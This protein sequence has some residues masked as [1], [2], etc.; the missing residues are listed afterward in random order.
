MD[1]RSHSQEP[2]GTGP[3]RKPALSAFL[4]A[5]VT[6]LLIYTIWAWAGLRPSFQVAAVAAAWI[7]LGGLMFGGGAASWRAATRDPVFYLGLLFLL[8]LVLQ[9]ANAGRMQYFDAGY[10][11]W[12]Y[13][14]PR[15]RGWPSAFAAADARQMLAWFFP[16]WVLVLVLR[17]PWLNR[18]ELRSLLMWLA[19]SAGL[20]AAFG[21]VQY[22]SG[23]Q[24]I[25]WRQPLSS[26]FFASFAYG[27]HA[28]AFFVLA[29]AL[30]AGL[31]YREVFDARHSPADTPSAAR[32]RHPGRVVF[33][34]PVLVLCLL[35]AFLGF[36]RAGVILAGLLVAFVVGY[37]WL[38][39]WR[40]L[41]PAARVN[42]AALS[43]AV[44]AVLF[45]AVASVG[46]TG[47][48]RE[49]RRLALA[50]GAAPTLW[51]HVDRE[52]GR[53]P[54]FVWAALQ[55]WREHPWVGTGGWGFKYLVAERVPQE[56]W[57][58]LE[59]R[60]W[61]NVHCD[62]V[63]FLAEFGLV[64]SGLLLAAAGTLACGLCDRRRCRRDALWVMGVAGLGLVVLFS[65]VDLPFRSPA[66]LY[67][68]V[69]VLAVLP[70]LCRSSFKALP[71]DGPAPGGA[72][73]PPAPPG[74]GATV[75]ERTSR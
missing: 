57:P 34:V 60:G 23:T 40:V 59:R 1:A 68:W 7:L 10:R 11:K 32:L 12:M 75:E 58:A 50:P 8:L 45:F 6:G 54:H 5:G 20:L 70:R 24:A 43:L 51:E 41:Q 18:R 73:A 44:A 3:A 72:G 53:R 55:I 27:N 22:L 37:G 64:G 36:S 38:R 16:A 4:Q 15:W 65:L 9:W 21:L 69:V 71:E 62:P 25:F 35:G 19:G 2:G 31:L 56:F 42:F 33:L 13:M 48:R 66:I 28:P 26:H 29:S 63:Q 49:F 47:I 74:A 67:T 17:S 46:E 14:P 39:S 61:A 52:L 30:T